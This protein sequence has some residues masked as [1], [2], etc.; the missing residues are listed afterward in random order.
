[1][2]TNLM[3]GTIWKGSN[4]Q[5]TLPLTP[6]CFTYITAEN[7]EINVYTEVSGTSITYGET[8]MAISGNNATIV[9]QPVQLDALNDGIIR[10]N[11]AMDADGEHYVFDLET[12][13]MLKTPNPYTPIEG[14]YILYVTHDYKDLYYRIKN[15]GTEE[16]A[17]IMGNI[18][19]YS[20]PSQV[21]YSPVISY[22]VAGDIIY[23]QVIHKVGDNGYIGEYEIGTDGVLKSNGRSKLLNQD[24]L[25]SAIDAETARTESTYLKEHQSLEGYATEQYVNNAMDAEIARTESRYVNIN[26]LADFT[27]K[28]YVEDAISAETART[29]TT[30]QHILTAGDNITIDENNVIS[31]TGGGGG[32]TNYYLDEMSAAEKENLRALIQSDIKNID[33]I[34]V[35][36]KTSGNRYC[37]SIAARAESTGRVMFYFLFDNT[38]RMYTIEI[39]GNTRNIDTNFA[40]EQWVQNQG[41]LTEHQDISGKVNNVQGVTGLW[42]GTQA[43]YDALGT[44]D[45]NVLYVIE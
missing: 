40:T 33:K 1:M 18:Y 3:S 11:V 43:Q 15:A 10:Y 34:A 21:V 39:N 20:Y 6:K 45:N 7:I 2:E 19:I 4:A 16:R 5:I 29:E 25:T 36:L 8:E 42:R 35:W 17:R 30:Y 23:M 22:K 28:Q 9:M 13:W 26:S 37:E 44:Y 41:Y 14:R 38:Y 32:K 24:N 27:T 31:A 12:R